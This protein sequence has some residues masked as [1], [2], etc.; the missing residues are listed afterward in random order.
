MSFLG[1]FFGHRDPY[2]KAFDPF[3]KRVNI[4][5]GGEV[6]LRDLA[7]VPDAIRPL[8]VTQ[9]VNSEVHNGGFA[10]LFFNSTG[11]LVPEAIAGFRTLGMPMIADIVS[12]ATTIF[13]M[14]YP[15]D[16]E[17]RLNLFDLPDKDEDGRVVFARFA[18]LTAP[19]L[20]LL[21]KT[22]WQIMAVE[23]GVYTKAA[24]RYAKSIQ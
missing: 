16:R 13:P 24:N 14:P 15:R 5:D 22:F 11:V 21:D 6:F 19:K 3:W 20:D 8:L 10:Q 7:V 23:N 18:E 17:Q 1:S 2:K 9:W 4:Y 12:A